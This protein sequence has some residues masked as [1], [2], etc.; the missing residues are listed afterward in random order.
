[1][2]TSSIVQYIGGAILAI[3]GI[4]L[5][6]DASRKLRRESTKSVE[7][8]GVLASDVLLGSVLDKIAWRNPFDDISSMIGGEEDE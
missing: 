1:M 4:A 7:K 3:G 8:F 2:S 5:A 6:S